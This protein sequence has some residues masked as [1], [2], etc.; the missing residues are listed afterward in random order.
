VFD[1]SSTDFFYL[2]HIRICF[3][4]TL[5]ARK[6]LSNCPSFIWSNCF[7]NQVFN[8]NRLFYTCHKLSN[9]YL[10]ETFIRHNC[11]VMLLRS[12]FNVDD[13]KPIKIRIGSYVKLHHQFCIPHTRMSAC[14][15]SFYDFDQ[16]SRSCIIWQFAHKE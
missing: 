6:Y 13:Y 16:N 4:I 3:A 7:I 11:G 9:Q 2:W 14:V 5:S 10:F 1:R 12:M 8:E 15:Q